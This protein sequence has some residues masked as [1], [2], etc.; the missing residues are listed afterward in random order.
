MIIKC[1]Y[2]FNVEDFA[3]HIIENYQEDYEEDWKKELAKYLKWATDET[4]NSLKERIQ[5]TVYEACDYNDNLKIN[6]SC[7]DEIYVN[8]A[9]CLCNAIFAE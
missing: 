9:S 7:L 6:W 5:D 3:D 8:V 2:D 1:E 4:N